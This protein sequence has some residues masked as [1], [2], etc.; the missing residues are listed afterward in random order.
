MVGVPSRKKV[1]ATFMNQLFLNF[2]SES[3]GVYVSPY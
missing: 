1:N 3:I 2:A